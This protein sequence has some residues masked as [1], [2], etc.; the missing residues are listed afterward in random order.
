MKKK[1][2]AV[3]TFGVIALICAA[4]MAQHAWL[5]PAFSQTSQA[6]IGKPRI[7]DTV[8]ANMYADNWFVL[9]I[10]GELTAVDSIKFMPHNVIS[11][12][13]LPAYPMTIAVMAKDNADATTG[14]EYANTNIGDAGF[15]LK[16]GDGTVT[17][18]NWKAKAFSRGPMDHDTKNP[19]VENSPIPEDWYAIDFNDS[20]WGKAKVYTQQQVG[21]KE[22]FFEHDF[23]GAEFIWTDDIELDNTVIFRHFVTT[24]PDGKSRPDFSN[25]ND[26]VP[27]SPPRKP[28]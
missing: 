3:M 18:A 9:Y 16:F 8:K 22:P 12:E 1:Q 10:N 17:N 25:L 21:P 19:Q 20:S 7:S 15:I 23:Q 24:P 26:I 6:K 28:R 11:V 13:I 5:A 27:D 4:L 14:M 2:T